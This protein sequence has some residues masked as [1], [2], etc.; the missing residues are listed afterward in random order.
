MAHVAIC[1]GNRACC[2]ARFR[3]SL[4][5]GEYWHAHDVADPGY[6]DVGCRRARAAGAG[7]RRW[8]PATAGALAGRDARAAQSLAGHRPDRPARP[9]GAAVAVSVDRARRR[10]LPEAGRRARGAAQPQSPRLL[11]RLRH[12]HLPGGL[13]PARPGQRQ[14]DAGDAAGG[15]LPRL[16]GLVARR[17]ALRVRQHHRSW[18]GTVGWRRPRRQRAPDRRR[19][20]EHHPRR[21]RAV[22]GRQART[23]CHPGARRP[24][25]DA[26]EGRGAARSGDEGG[27]R[28]QG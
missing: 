9:A 7:G 13:Q 27:D 6:S 16:P 14:G 22:A 23:A 5:A 4:I 8:L 15:R 17:P 21:R 2:R 19:A 10:T 12:P 18:R 1:A 3:F 28:R 24:R 11:Q 20:S 26:A 25:P